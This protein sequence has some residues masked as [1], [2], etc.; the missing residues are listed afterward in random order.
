MK[1]FEFN[2]KYYGMFVKKDI[3][4]KY[5][6]NN[7]KENLY[8][9]YYENDKNEELFNRYYKKNE[10]PLIYEAYSIG[11]VSKCCYKNGK[12]KWRIY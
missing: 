3:C 7:K 10:Y 11:V 12:K 4:V 5:Y 2:G 6:E 8:I 1:N 9:R